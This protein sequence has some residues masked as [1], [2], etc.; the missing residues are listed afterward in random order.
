MNGTSY[1]LGINIVYNRGVHIA[2][3]IPVQAWMVPECSWRLR[4]PELKTVGTCS[5]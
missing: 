4:F 3:G 5:W 1:P 2:G